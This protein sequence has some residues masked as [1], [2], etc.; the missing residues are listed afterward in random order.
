MAPPTA[1]RDHLVRAL[2]ADLVGPFA[3]GTPEENTA[4]E[5]LPLPPS[6]WYLTGFLAPEEGRKQEDP[7]A[8]HDP[9]AED[10]LAAGSDETEE[11][12]QGQ[13]PESKRKNFLPASLGMSVLLA[14]ACQ[15][16]TATLRFAEYERE[17][18]ETADSDKPRTAFCPNSHR[19]AITRPHGDRNSTSHPT[20]TAS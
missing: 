11:E 18:L 6:R 5:V 19:D 9:E 16:I 17:K 8:A 1:T 10:E 7:D 12:T 4:E 14:P 2:K 15:T 13:E 20:V 3:A